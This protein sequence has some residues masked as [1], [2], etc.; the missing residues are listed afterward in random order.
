[1]RE[2][3]RYD[4]TKIVR[5]KRAKKGSPYYESI[6][7]TCKHCGKTVITEEGVFDKRTKFCDSS[8]ERKYWRH[9]PENN[10]SS[11]FVYYG[12]PDYDLKE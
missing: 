8:C 9:P 2:I 3:P 6:T 11:M 10:K 1:M 5:N 12:K 7:F 4:T